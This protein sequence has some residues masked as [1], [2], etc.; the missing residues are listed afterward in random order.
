MENNYFGDNG[1]QSNAGYPNQ[2]GLPVYQNQQY[3]QGYSSQQYNQGYS[4]QQYNQGYSNQQ[5]NQGYQ[6]QQYNQGYSNQQYNQGYQNQQYG[7]VDKNNIDPRFKPISVWG[8]IGYL[9]LFGIPIIGLVLM[10]IFSFDS[11]YIARRN[12]SRAILLSIL[13][14]AILCIPAALIVSQSAVDTVS[15]VPFVM[16]SQEF[17]EYSNQ[18]KLDS[19]KVK[20]NFGIEAIEINDAQMYYITSHGYDV[21]KKDIV[22]ENKI[23]VGYDLSIYDSQF[24]KDVLKNILHS[25]DNEVAY[26]INDDKITNY[27]SDKKILDNNLD[28]SA[29][30]EFYG[31]S[32]GKEYH[33]VTSEGKVFT[34]PG[35]PCEQSDGSIEY[36]I[37]SKNGHYYVVKGKSKINVGGTNINGDVVSSTTPMDAQKLT[38]V[39]GYDYEDN[40]VNQLADSEPKTNIIGR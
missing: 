36:H 9:V 4:N 26:I 29:S 32:N 22:T 16:F 10:I 7:P 33:F 2:S 34:L 21:D 24:D 28:G 38:K 3:N 37:D 13:L 30:R 8:H 27:Y 6:N 17:D 35:F 40:E 18:V 23:P 31:D 5:Y 19:I 12:Y 11:N 15:H 1:S 14:S 39:K 20:M 25:E